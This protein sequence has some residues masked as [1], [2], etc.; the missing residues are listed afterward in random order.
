MNIT[1]LLAG[2]AVKDLDGNGVTIVQVRE[3]VELR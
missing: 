2:V 1:N 3:G